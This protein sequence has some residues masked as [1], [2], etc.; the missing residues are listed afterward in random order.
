MPLG[1]EVEYSRKM[2]VA[3][4]ISRVRRGAKGPVGEGHLSIAW[5]V[6]AYWKLG[7]YLQVI[8]RVGVEEIE[9]FRQVQRTSNQAKGGSRVKVASRM[10]LGDVHE[11]AGRGAHNQRGSSAEHLLNTC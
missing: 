1:E 11:I 8:E 4:G 3:R 7:L 2:L 5:T 9:L 6:P 10:L